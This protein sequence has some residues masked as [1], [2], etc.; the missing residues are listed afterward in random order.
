M[1]G[2]AQTSKTESLEAASAR[3]QERVTS[4][5]QILNF[6]NLYGSGLTESVP[7]LCNG[8]AGLGAL[9][10]LFVNRARPEWRQQQFELHEV[11]AQRYF[12]Y[13][14]FSETYRRCL[15]QNA[16]NIDIVHCHDMWTIHALYAARAARR[17]RCKFV[18]SPRGTL[19]P[20]AFRRAHWHK[21]LLWH[22]F[23]RANLA[24]VD[25]LHVTS[26]AEY[27]VV[28][29]LGCKQPVA[30]I[31]N[32]VTVPQFTSKVHERQQHS[33][34]VLLYFGRIHP[35]KGL[36]NLVR[37]WKLVHHALPEWK[38]RI[39]GLDEGG[40]TLQLKK[41]VAA[42]GMSAVSFDDPV[43]GDER[44]QLYR[45]AN[46]YVLPSRSENFGIT[47]A[48]ALGCERPVIA[49]QGTPWADLVSRGCGWWV[50]ANTTALAD[51][52]L[53]ACSQ[54]DQTLRQ[55]GQLGRKWIEE[56]FQWEV[57]AK[58]TLHVYEWLTGKAD[59]PPFVRAD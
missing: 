55:M 27:E 11:P 25:C 4:S 53:L 14:G 33:H 51:S 47:V 16:A 38:L 44:F 3:T 22:G 24:K 19:F 46:V 41:L 49:S 42:L 9:V 45:E 37:A 58:Q 34:K 36:D 43:F 56:C 12:E 18:V 26:E 15:Y 8:L 23:Q 31:P 57:V 35:I 20:S 17:N 7:A 28:R 54:S 30:V 48:E 2:S 52:I 39:V 32:G 21:Q 13:L 1:N 29:S 6:R 59:R 5:L 10:R 50:N 40:Y